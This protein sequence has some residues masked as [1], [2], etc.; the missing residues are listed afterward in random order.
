MVT[1]EMRFLSSVTLGGNNIEH[2][3]S[4]LKQS[5]ACD[6]RWRFGPSTPTTPTIHSWITTIHPRATAVHPVLGSPPFAGGAPACAADTATKRRGSP[7]VGRTAPLGGLPGG[8][9]PEFGSRD[10]H[11]HT[12]VLCHQKPTTAGQRAALD[13]AA[14]EAFVGV[15][16]HHQQRGVGLGQC[17]Q[18]RV[19]ARRRPATEGTGDDHM[20]AD[21]G[22][23]GPPWRGL[24][25]GRIEARRQRR[26]ALGT[27]GGALCSGESKPGGSCWTSSM[28]RK[29]SGPLHQARDNRSSAD[30]P[31]GGSRR[32]NTAPSSSIIAATPSRL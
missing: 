28:I 30:S 8:L 3:C 10:L 26:G 17:P 31:G 6:I 1:D 27:Q 25:H 11:V 12:G 14:D 5:L 15:G 18:H 9:P 24:A 23:P 2:V 16:V 7:E 20:Q 13:L 19:A 32:A 22:C 29:I 21:I 4:S